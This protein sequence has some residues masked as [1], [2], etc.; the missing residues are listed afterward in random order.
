MADQLFTADTYLQPFI[1][2]SDPARES[3]IFP[4]GRLSHVGQVG[5]SAAA[6]AGDDL[7]L[8]LPLP[9]NYAYRLRYAHFGVN[10]NS[11]SNIWVNSVLRIF[12]SPVEEVTTD[13]VTALEWSLQG[14]S[15]ASSNLERFY[16]VLDDI[17]P[18]FWVT[19]VPAGVS[20]WN[21]SMRWT[22]SSGNAVGGTLTYVV[23]W[24]VINVEQRNHVGVN[25]AIPVT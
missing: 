8:D 4:F 24:D 10:V 12:W 18:D 16:T 19:Q 2:E 20:T 21:P 6:A 1:T 15:T 9:T 17:R 5:I 11:G 3:S 23:N 22:A 7:Q 25:T 14:N 13:T